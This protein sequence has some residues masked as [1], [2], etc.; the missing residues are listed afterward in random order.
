M[1][2][3]SGEQ[4]IREKYNA[5]LRLVAPGSPLREG[6]S[7]ILQSGTGGLL[8]LDDSKRVEKLCEGGVTIDRP[9][10]PTLLYELSKMDGAIVLNDV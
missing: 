9:F 3:K 4:R 5:A 2:K 10:R 7:Y 8:V 1:A 6:L